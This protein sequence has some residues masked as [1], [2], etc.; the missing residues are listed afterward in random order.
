MKYFTLLLLSVALLFGATQTQKALSSKGRAEVRLQNLVE[1]GEFKKAKE[2]TRLAVAKY[3]DNAELLRWGGQLY[4]ELNDL[5]EAKRFFLLAMQIDP[6][7]EIVRMHLESIESQESASEN[8]DV[9]GLIEFIN[10]K[11]LDFLMIF[12]GF[13][14][15][16]IIAKRYNVCQNNK[17]L[18]MADYFLEREDI[19]RC[20][21][22]QIRFALLQF[23]AKNIFSF[24]FVI[25]LLIIVTISI[26]LSIFYLF[27]AFK[28]EWALFLGEKILTI[29]SDAIWTYSLGVFG[30]SMLITVFLR[31][32][33]R[34]L[35][36]PEDTTLY[37]IELVEEIDALYD[38]GSYTD[39]YDVLSILVRD[40]KSKE[41][42]RGLIFKYSKEPEK[43]MNFCKYGSE[44]KK[45]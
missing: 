18:I 13:L 19:S 4:K 39:I 37:E 40:E 2:F 28:L 21:K 10:D 38:G 16:E 8:K 41:E 42:I 24:C 31:A 12:L 20:R 27:L 26:V 14:G 45:G 6:N 29:D 25:N 35:S 23:K 36:L 1:D 15:A 7:N 44:K 32:Y 5:D 43:I 34:Y 9:E 30:V 33:M 22:S 3:G 11:G 17:I